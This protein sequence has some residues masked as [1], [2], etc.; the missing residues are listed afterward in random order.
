M[1]LISALVLLAFVATPALS[2]DRARQTT[3]QQLSSSVHVISLCQLKVRP[4]V[5][6]VQR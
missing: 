5:R 6:T 3:V 1:R 2:A 4:F